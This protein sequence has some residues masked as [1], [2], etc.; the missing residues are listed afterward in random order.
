MSKVEFIRSYLIIGAILCAFGLLLILF[1]LVAAP[2][3]WL[4]TE[5]TVRTMASGT[6]IGGF[7]IIMGTI[8][9]IFGFLGQKSKKS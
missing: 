7:S 2:P 6:I 9:L 5:E 1:I 4:R 3:V 8:F